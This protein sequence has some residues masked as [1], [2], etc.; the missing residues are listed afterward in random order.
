MVTAM[1]SVTGPYRGTNQDSVGCSGSYV[2][3]A[4]GVG[5][6]A[7]GDVASW[8]ITHRLMSALSPVGRRPLDAEHLRELI[9]VANADLSLRVRAEPELRGMATTFTGLF[10]GEGTMTIAHIGDS[11]AYLVRDGQ[12]RRMTRDD[13]LVQALVDAGVIDEAE[14]QHHPRRNVIMRSLAGSA[15]DAQEMT[16]LTVPTQVGDRWLVASDGL[17]DYV[18]EDELGGLLAG[19]DVE[20]AADRLLAA[21]EAADSRDN[22]SL[23]VSDVVATADLADAPYRYLG[24]AASP[25]RGA[26]ADLSR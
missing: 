18:T 19:G 26:V 6:H 10:C 4:D 17:T 8:T 7:G 11:R 25:T 21:A 2:F 22:V 5:G 23:A 16:L 14:A 15:T 1:R 20:V 9:A 24:A 13:S 3:V 12:L